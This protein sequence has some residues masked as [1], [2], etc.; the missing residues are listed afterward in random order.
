MTAKV[1]E[2]ALGITAPWSV[3]AVEFDDSAKVLTVRVDFETGSRFTVS[4]HEGMH[5]VHDTVIKIWRSQG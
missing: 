2:V 4:G 3:A 5:P 1:F